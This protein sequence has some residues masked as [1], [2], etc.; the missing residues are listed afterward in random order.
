MCI[1]KL[2][3]YLARLVHRQCKYQAGVGLDDFQ[4]PFQAWKSQTLRFPWSSQRILWNDQKDYFDS[5]IY[6]FKSSHIMLMRLGTERDN[7]IKHPASVH[8]G[9]KI[10]DLRVWIS[11]H[12][13]S[14]RS[15]K[16][17][18]SVTSDSL[19]PMDCSLPGSYVHRIFQA[20]VLELV[21]I[22]QGACRKK[23]K[24]ISLVVQWLRL[25][26][27]MQGVQVTSLLEELR[28]HMPCGQKTR[29]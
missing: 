12:W 6:I 2:G 4:S 20:R 5:Y 28:S 21:A 9:R 3:D 24:G 19:Q 17:S 27:P 7:K 22:T 11:V 26:L 23:K 8:L 25:Y 1:Q 15:L 29:T 14:Q 16:W 13:S 10:S 18:R